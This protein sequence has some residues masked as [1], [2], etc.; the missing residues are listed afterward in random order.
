MDYKSLEQVERVKKYEAL[1]DELSPMI[2]E[3]SESLAKLKSKQDDIKELL[4]Y[5]G[6]DVWFTDVEDADNEDLIN[7]KRGILSEDTLWDFYGD[8][9]ELGVEMAQTGLDIIK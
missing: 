8:Y 1:Y 7:I 3:F 4:E 9:R 6:S 2:E 5:Y